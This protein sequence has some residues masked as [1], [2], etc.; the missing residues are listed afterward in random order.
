MI[1]SKRTKSWHGY[2]L[3]GGIALALSLRVA[4]YA[5]DAGPG[6][7]PFPND[8]G[9]AQ[10]DVSGYPQDIQADYKIFARRCSQCHSLSRP[11]NS[12]FLQL[13]VDEQKPSQAKEPDLFKDSK[14]WQ[15]SD[16]VWTDYV[17]KMQSKPGAI[18]RA[19]EFDKIVAFLAYDS[20][21]RKTGASKDSW[22]ATRQKLL[23]GFKKANPKRY[24]EIFGK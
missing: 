16:S 1:I 12:Q 14:V 17:K 18:I 8:G 10:V 20:K 15:I 19:S 23:D 7:P 4:S 24:E 2:W 6:G 21:A 11:L 9:E 3:A 5:E 13:T 22:H